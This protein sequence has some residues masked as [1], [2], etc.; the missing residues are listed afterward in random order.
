MNLP[1]KKWHTYTE[2][3]DTPA[4]EMPLKK[5]AVVAIFDNPFAGR[6]VEDLNPLIQASIAIGAAM[7]KVFVEAMQ[8]YPIIGI[9]KGGITGLSG[10]QEHVNA[11][12]TTAFAEP[13]RAAIG[14]GK[15]WIPSMTKRAG[16]GTLIDIPLAHKDALYV[17]S[18]YDGV[19]LTLPEAPAA[20]EIAL[21]LAGSNRGRLQARVGGLRVEDVKGLDGLS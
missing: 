21:I 3:I 2:T 10:E 17:R 7:G 16:P 18:F 1:I 14:G 19:S 12:L 11:L 20:D 6:F 15:A 8:P 4:G 9:G 13:V 5:I